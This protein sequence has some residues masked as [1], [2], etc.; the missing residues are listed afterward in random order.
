MKKPFSLRRLQGFPYSKVPDPGSC[1]PKDYALEIIG[2][3]I[4]VIII[5]ALSPV[6]VIVLFAMT[7]RH[8]YRGGVV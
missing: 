7:A 3:A 2:T 5:L 8:L 1:P 4:E 6:I